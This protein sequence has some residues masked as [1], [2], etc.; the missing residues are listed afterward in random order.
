MFSDADGDALTLSAVTSNSAVA[1]IVAQL[2]PVTG[3][4]TAI[5]VTGV[6][7][8]TATITV[9]AQDSDGN[10]V[11]DAFEVIVPAADSLQEV[12]TVPGPV[13]DLTLTVKGD[14]VVVSWTAPE[15]GSTP[16]GYI[17][18]LKPEGGETGSGKTKRPKAKKT[19]V[20]YNKLEAGVTYNVWVRAQNESGKGERLHATITLPPPQETAG[21]P[22]Q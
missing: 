4:A 2:D 5:T 20:T 12:S 11:S 10:Q 13:I 7:A 22:G 15:I 18:H 8:G 21:P 17:V 19:K 9:T 14:K 16:R 1:T 6:S 3:S